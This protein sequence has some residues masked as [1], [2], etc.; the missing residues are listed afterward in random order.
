LI[1]VANRAELA[2]LL[3]YISLPSSTAVIIYHQI[4]AD[5]LGIHVLD[6]VAES[7]EDLGNLEGHLLESLVERSQLLHVSIMIPV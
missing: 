1:I 7:L 2:F 5:H 3:F 4:L 6:L